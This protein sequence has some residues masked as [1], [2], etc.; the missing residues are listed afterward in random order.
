MSFVISSIFIIFISICFALP[1][2]DD[3]LQTTELFACIERHIPIGQP[4]KFIQ[5]GANDG[6][7]Y[8]LLHPVMVD[9]QQHARQ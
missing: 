8:D 6:V 7:M 4:V 1:C 3:S 2:R 9:S 5:I